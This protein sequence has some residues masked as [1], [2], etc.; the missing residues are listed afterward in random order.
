[1]I[2][3]VVSTMKPTNERFLS[4]TVSRWYI[5]VIHM[6]TITINVSEP[7]YRDFQEYARA[8]DRPAAE[9]IRQAMEEY[10]DRRIRRRASIREVEP[11]RLGKMLRDIEPE[12]DLF[13]E[14]LGDLRT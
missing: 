14:M 3:G 10:R 9:V 11:L 12:A 8:V 4:L 1:M 2:D 5:T 7:V 6:K 13:E